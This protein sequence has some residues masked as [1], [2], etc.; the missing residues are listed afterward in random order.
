VECIQDEAQQRRF[1]DPEALFSYLRTALSAESQRAATSGGCTDAH[2]ELPAGAVDGR[3][4]GST[5]L[6]QRPIL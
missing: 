2:Q 1:R 3:S 4:T 5:A 6:D